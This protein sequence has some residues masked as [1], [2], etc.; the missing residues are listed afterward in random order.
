M[1]GK[2]VGFC[3]LAPHPLNPALGMGRDPQFKGE[4][5]DFIKLVVVYGPFLIEI[6]NCQCWYG[7]GNNDSNNNS[8][9]GSN[10]ALNDH[11][12]MKILIFSYRRIILK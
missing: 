1:P 8:N 9:I 11:Q 7:N 2:K 3:P 12:K 6:L 10:N 4:S 5:F